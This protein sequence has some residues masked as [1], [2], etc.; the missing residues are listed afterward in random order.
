MDEKQE[1]DL[2]KKIE[3]TSVPV[4]FAGIVLPAAV[5]AA[6]AIGASLIGLNGRKTAGKIIKKILG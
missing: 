2:K 1:K 4:L 5:M 6:Y 3:E